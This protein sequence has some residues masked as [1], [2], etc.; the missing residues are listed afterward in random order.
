MSVLK[1]LGI[2]WTNLLISF[3]PEE[4]F[5]LGALLGYNICKQCERF[6]SRKRNLDSEIFLR[7]RNVL[8]S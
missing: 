1:P 3:T 5:I 4:D 8:C 7:H 2:Y 6:C